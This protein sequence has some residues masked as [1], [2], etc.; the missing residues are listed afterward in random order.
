MP[1]FQRGWSR[2]ISIRRHAPQEI[3][4][5]AHRR[6]PAN[7]LRS[8]VFRCSSTRKCSFHPSQVPGRVSFIN[9]FEPIGEEAYYRFAPKKLV[10]LGA[11]PPFEGVSAFAL[12][13]VLVGVDL[14]VAKVFFFEGDEEGGGD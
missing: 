4:Q 6:D 7:E 13:F 9:K 8:S 5:Y 12:P 11:S 3:S 1:S 2:A 10:I 14:G